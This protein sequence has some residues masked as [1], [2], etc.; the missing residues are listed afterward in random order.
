MR[1]KSND[2]QSASITQ[3]LSALGACLL[4]VLAFSFTLPATRIASAELRPAILGFGRA[5]LAAAL[6]AVLLW[7]GR[8][9][10]PPRRH[11]GALAAVAC[12]GVLGFPWLTSMALRAAPAHHAVVVIG[13]VPLCTALFAS[14]RGP[15]RLSRSFWLAASCGAATVLLFATREHGFTLVGDDL[16]LLLAVVGVAVGYAEGGR[17]AV[18]LGGWQVICWALVFAAP[19]SVL[20]LGIDLYRHGVPALS[21]SSA[22]AFLY[23]SFVSQV[24]GFCLWYRGL[25]GCGV[26]RGSQVQ[27]LQPLLSL[28]WCAALLGEPLAASTVLAAGGVLA[29]VCVAQR[30][31]R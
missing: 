29:S 26:A 9:R 22:T 18:E 6:A 19:V 21:W 30:A 15:E 31:R 8:A 28:G 17:A 16:L 13:L 4:A 12:G 11:A 20:L 24:L 23:V 5:S 1:S 10:L 7:R 27:L 14:L 2:T 3:S 25:S